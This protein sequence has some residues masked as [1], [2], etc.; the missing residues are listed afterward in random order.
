MGSVA[1]AILRSL[2]ASKDLG[3]ASYARAGNPESSETL[4]GTEKWFSAA[5]GG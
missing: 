2:G 1:T 4:Q 3:C 5:C